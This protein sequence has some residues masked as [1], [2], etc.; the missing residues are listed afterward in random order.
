MFE[1]WFLLE[2]LA[3]L[4]YGLRLEEAGRRRAR[5][6]SLREARSRRAL[7]RALKGALAAGLYPEE[8]RAAL[9]RALKAT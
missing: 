9:S 2:R 5:S 4:E 8:L 7:E 6:A 3:Q 1:S